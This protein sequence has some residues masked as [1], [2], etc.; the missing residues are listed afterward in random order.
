MDE[1]RLPEQL[2]GPWHHALLLTFGADIP[3]FESV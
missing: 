1:L 2:S 3:F